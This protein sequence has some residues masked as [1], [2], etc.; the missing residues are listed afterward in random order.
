MALKAAIIMSVISIAMLVIYG[1]DVMIAGHD[2]GNDNGNEKTGFLQMNASVRGSIFGIVPSAM[3]II[4]FFITRKEPSE[5]LGILIII[6]G[7]LIIVGTAIILGM[8]GS[9]L[10]DR[11][12]RE[13]GAVLA[14]GIIIVILGVLK[15]RKSTRIAATG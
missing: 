8:E 1:V 9:N 2:T 10:P 7:A 6:G 13:F 11:A 3:L 5:K 12:M 15:I 14:I 4:S